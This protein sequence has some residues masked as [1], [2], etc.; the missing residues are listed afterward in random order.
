MKLE[1]FELDHSDEVSCAIC[2]SQG[3]FN[4]YKRGQAYL[5]PPGWWSGDADYICKQHL[6]TGSNAAGE[7]LDIVDVY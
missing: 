6:E 4:I 2:N 3:K 7:E 1:V 5:C